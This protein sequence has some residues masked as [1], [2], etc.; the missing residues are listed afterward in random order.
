MRALLVSV[1][2]TLSFILSACGGGGGGSSDPGV[3]VSLGLNFDKSRAAAD[4]FYVSNTKI[5]SV[6]V[7]YTNNA[8][9]SGSKN[10]TAQAADGS[11][12]LN[13]LVLNSTYTFTVLAMAEGNVQACT[14]STSVLIAENEEN[15]ATIECVFVDSLAVGN[16]VYDFVE[17][18]MSANPTAANI[19]QYVANDFGTYDGYNRAQFIADLL[20]E[21]GF[22][23]TDPTVQLE[24]VEV[25]TGV[26]RAAATESLIKFHFSD[27]SVAEEYVGLVKEDGKWKLTGNGKLYEADIN[28]QAYYIIPHSASPP[29]SLFYSGVATEFYDPAN[30]VSGID[31]SATPM[32]ETYSFVRATCTDCDGFTIDYP[33]TLD[34]PYFFS[35]HYIDLFEGGANAAVAADQQYTLNT[36]YTNSTQDTFNLTAYGKPVQTSLLDTTYFPLLPSTTSQNIAEYIAN[37]SYTFTLIKPTAYDAQLIE[38][39]LQYRDY[40]GNYG[41]IEGLIPLNANTFTVDFSE[42]AGSF[43]T[44]ASVFIS[45]YDS[46]GRVFTTVIELYYDAGTATLSASGYT[47]LADAISK[48]STAQLAT[49]S[50]IVSYSSDPGVL[51]ILSEISDA[52]SLGLTAYDVSGAYG[53]SLLRAGQVSNPYTSGTAQYIA[54]EN[55]IDAFYDLLS[56]N[57][58]VAMDIAVFVT[59]LSDDGFQS[60]GVLLGI[61]DEEGFAVYAQV[62]SGSLDEI[63]ADV[64]AHTGTTVEPDD[65]YNVE[66][67]L[68]YVEVTDGSTFFN[69]YAT[70]GVLT[71]NGAVLCNSGAYAS[72]YVENE[73]GGE[74]YAINS[75]GD[76]IPLCN[77]LRTIDNPSSNY[78]G[79]SYVVLT[80]IDDMSY[81]QNS[82]VMM[83]NPEG[84]MVWAKEY[85]ALAPVMVNDAELSGDN[86]L[87]LYTDTNDNAGGFIYEVLPDGSTGMSSMIS[88]EDSLSSNPVGS[89]QFNDLILK[90]GVFAILGTGR[91]DGGDYLEPLVFYG[92]YATT[93]TT[94]MVAGGGLLNHFYSVEMSGDFSGQFYSGT[95][96]GTDLIMSAL[97]TGQ[98][99]TVAISK[100]D[101]TT[102]TFYNAISFGE[103]IPE[104]ALVVSAPDSTGVTGN[105]LFTNY[106]DDRAE[107]LKFSFDID[108]ELVMENNA[109]FDLY[110]EYGLS[111]DI[112][113]VTSDGDGHLLFAGGMTTEFSTD[114]LMGAM[115]AD[116]LT[117]NDEYTP[118]T[119]MDYNFDKMADVNP[120]NTLTVTLTPD[121]FINPGDIVD[122]ADIIS[123]DNY[124]VDVNPAMSII[125]N[126]LM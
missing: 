45:A 90:D 109:Q 110:S 101:T 105:Y 23:F 46:E 27:G 68:D 33:Y 53:A 122:I 60:L 59:E 86:L 63:I 43:I 22:A 34:T 11:V 56:S 113:A 73:E 92:T 79:Y 84:A 1:L 87:V 61:A 112:Y 38:I 48:M 76:Q 7:S 5:D 55:L 18:L 52:A 24:S 75:T 21:P 78:N 50:N 97:L 85:P 120:V 49:F 83:L 6:T 88:G 37:A 12:E 30:V 28:T 80:N 19:D 70:S 35:D 100:L 107:I 121:V 64:E 10:V 62:L 26:A 104:D 71:S 89:V 69:L 115:S 9:S 16:A 91:V 31:V 66:E 74:L 41:D 25:F 123:L 93:T 124:I 94:T 99:E 126:M 108:G 67:G 44:D 98:G 15:T 54:Y 40:Y 114:L 77:A 102:G 17:T 42:L 111:P 2:I 95:Y 4:G 47:A 106:I 119:Q 51:N 96:S 39:D 57:P 82:I 116:D 81:L 117:I 36:T 65:G 3:R 125:V 72:I 20:D 103:T 58:D 13:G 32:S 29:A 14:G 8:G 118:G